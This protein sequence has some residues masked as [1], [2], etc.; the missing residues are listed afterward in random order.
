MVSH[1][2][3]DGNS[4]ARLQYEKARLK[5]AKVCAL[6]LLESKRQA[7]YEKGLVDFDILCARPY[8]QY[9]AISVERQEVTI[10]M[11][12]A[13]VRDSTMAP[14]R[15]VGEFI[16]AMTKIPLDFTCENITRTVN[17]HHHPHVAASRKMCGGISQIHPHISDGNFV[18]AADT[19]WWALNQAH[20]GAYGQAKPEFW[21]IADPQPCQKV[22][23]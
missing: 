23:K 8:I 7:Q 20:S 4:T 22:P 19:I 1:T 18:E 14:W 2:P 9:V 5:Y 15:E 6:G 16:V 11:R 13:Y 17:D 21:P 3:D 10:G 12:C